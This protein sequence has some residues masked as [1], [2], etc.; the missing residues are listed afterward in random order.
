ATTQRRTAGAT[1]DGTLVA[2]GGDFINAIGFSGWSA[3]TEGP[4]KMRYA[5][6]NVRT[7]QYPAK[8][9]LP[10]MAA[11]RP[12]GFVEGT[13]ALECLIDELAAKLGIDP[14]ELRRRNYADS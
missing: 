4:M 2:L 6:D 7:T 5:C 10:P 12:P 11:F 1:S 13:F 14:L 8:L 3:T 9:N